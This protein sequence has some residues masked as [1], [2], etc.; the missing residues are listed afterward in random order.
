M[1]EKKKGVTRREVL[2]G[3]GIAGTGFGLAWLFEKARVFSP[4]RGEAIPTTVPTKENV[5]E[6]VLYERDG[7]TVWGSAD[8]IPTR[9]RDLNGEGTFDQTMIQEA[10]AQSNKDHH[11]HI[12]Q[13]LR[14]QSNKPEAKATPVPESKTE[15]ITKLPD[16][17]LTPEQLR[18]HN[19]EIVGAA[20]IG[21]HIRESAFQPGGIFEKNFSDPNRKLTIVIVDTP[22]ITIESLS[23][24]RYDSVR[25]VLA[26][27]LPPVSRRRK[28]QMPPTDTNPVQEE[29]YKKSVLA[30]SD[31]EFVDWGLS[32]IAGFTNKKG[33]EIADEKGDYIVMAIG[34]DASRPKGIETLQVQTNP[35]SRKVSIHVGDVEIEEMFHPSRITKLSPDQNY[36]DPATFTELEH[37]EVGT[38]EWKLLAGIVPDTKDAIFLAIHECMH[39]KKYRELDHRNPQPTGTDRLSYYSEQVVDFETKALMERAYDH[40]KKTGDDS[41]YPFVFENKKENYFV[42]G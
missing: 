4:N 37:H 21:F 25:E 30:V 40:Y 15:K 27:N 18:Q 7:V 8:G 3:L 19:I 29:L 9:W 17:V 34:Q 28:T 36:T 38:L 10:Q 39:A 26:K 5:S 33:T 14:I 20:D 41:L 12:A 24:S 23:D 31:Q 16:D 22:T 35:N 42:I 13:V 11:A 2:A 1:N 6:S 32:G